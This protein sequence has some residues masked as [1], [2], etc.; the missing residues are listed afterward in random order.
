[1]ERSCIWLLRREDMKDDRKKSEFTSMKSGNIVVGIVFCII[2]IFITV[3]SMKLG[4][5]PSQRYGIKSGTWPAI[6]GMGMILFSVILL[7]YSFVNAKKL[8]DIDYQ[9]E[10]GEYPNRLTIHTRENFKAYIGMALIIV[11]VVMLKILGMYISTLIF[12]P[13]MMFFMMPDDVK[14]DRVKAVRKV[15]I[16]DVCTVL[17]IYLIFELALGTQLPAPIWK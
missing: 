9:N 5:G 15:L 11:F 6:M 7:I 4:F 3:N 16:I 17:A 10:H 13:I 2:G 8:S 12:L 1:V 14:A